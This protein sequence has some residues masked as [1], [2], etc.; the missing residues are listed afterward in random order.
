L[1][2]SLQD[3]IIKSR[4]GLE[5]LK[6]YKIEDL[7][8]DKVVIGALIET[9]HNTQKKIYFLIPVGGGEMV[10]NNDLSEK[11]TII[12]PESP[13]GAS[14]LEKRAGDL[15]KIGSGELTIIEIY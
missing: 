4:K 6:N 12:T 11:I 9:T 2:D 10:D 3:R 13:I 15:V 8:R 1:T 7:A 14:L 5:I